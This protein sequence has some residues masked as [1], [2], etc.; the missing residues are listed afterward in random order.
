[1]RLNNS[2]DTASKLVVSILDMESFFGFILI[3]SMIFNSF[4]NYTFICKKLVS[5]L[6]RFGTTG[7]E[8]QRIRN[9]ISWFESKTKTHRVAAT[10]YLNRPRYK[11]NILWYLK[12]RE[13]TMCGVCYC[14][15]PKIINNF[16]NYF[17]YQELDRLFGI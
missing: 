1:M 13:N 15:S 5:E 8:L 4:F 6:R 16:Q 10:T 2:E 17:H 11:L 12:N 3:D 7:L 9:G 14:V